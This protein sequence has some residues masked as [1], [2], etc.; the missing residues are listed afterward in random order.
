[1]EHLL[2]LWRTLALAE[3]VP[4]R[5]ERD[6]SDL[7]EQEKFSAA[8]YNR[9]RALCSGTFSLA[10]RNGKAV[11]NPVRGT[12]HRIENNARV[13][14]LSAEEEEKL[15][16]LVRDSCPEREAEIRVA[17]NS[18]MRLSEQYLTTDSPGGGLQWE[19]VDFQSGVMS[20]PKL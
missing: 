10:I 17:L 16:K 15:F 19:H 8:S 11:V 20:L 9:Y 4:G 3:L 14:Y 5:I 6:L 2:R 12:K 13:R 1:M 7:A 18:G